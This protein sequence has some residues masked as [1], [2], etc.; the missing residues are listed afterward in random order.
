MYYSSSKK[1]LR[2]F[3]L[4]E[5]LIVIVIIGLLTTVATAS[6]ISGQRNARDNAR[7]TQ[8]SSIA[9]AV[10]AYYNSKGAFPG[11][12]NSTKNPLPSG[13][14]QSTYN[15]IFND[16]EHIDSTGSFVYFYFPRQESNSCDK[17]TTNTTLNNYYDPDKFKPTPNW[18]P[19]LGEYL[20]PIPIDKR[21]QGANGTSTGSYSELLAAKDSVDGNK[22]RTYA[23]RHL[24][25]GYAV[26]TRLEKDSSDV[27]KTTPTDSPLLPVNPTGE[28]IFMIRK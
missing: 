10:E 22:T 2:G 4:I 13:T 26:Y 12:E 25:G 28:N 7:K 15:T 9:T 20:N 3:T 21:Y 27:L 24:S 11:K 19:G 23:Y 17:T 1:R 5:L 14:N 18:I 6:F 8:V 16:C